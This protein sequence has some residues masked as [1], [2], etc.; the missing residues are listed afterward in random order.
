MAV[1]VKRVEDFNAHSHTESG[2]SMKL[3]RDGLDVES[4]GMQVIDM[5]PD[6][7]AYPDHDHAE[8]GMEEVYVVLDGFATLHADGEEHRLEPGTVARVGAAQ[9]RKLV[10]GSDPVRL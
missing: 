8:E 2:M 10:T 6:C 4:F 3:A 7:D 1:T 9:K 5:P